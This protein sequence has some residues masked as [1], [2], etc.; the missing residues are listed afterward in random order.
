MTDAAIN[1]WGQ[2]A[3]IFT[4]SGGSTESFLTTRNGVI[5][6]SVP[7]ASST[8][9]LG[10]NNYDEVVGV[11][12]NSSGTH[13]FTWTHHGGFTTID[14]NASNAMPGTT[15]VNGVND[16]GQLVGSTPTPPATSTA[17]WSPP[18]TKT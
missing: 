14:D 3:G 5:T 6:L 1:D 2:I 16:P 9:A 17:C 7:G 10:V 18:A 13:G 8:Q 4:P 11:F 15:T 12:T